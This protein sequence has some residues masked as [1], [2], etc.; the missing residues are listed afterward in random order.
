[1][2]ER[3]PW[4]DD[5][6]A[7]AFAARADD[8]AA[9]TPADLATTTIQLIRDTAASSRGWHQGT[10]PIVAL[11][12]VAVVVAVVAAVTL[13]PRLSADRGAAT[14]PPATLPASTV[15][16]DGSA[17]PVASASRER[18]GLVGVRPPDHLGA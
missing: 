15:P 10:R 18:G 6:L 1:M 7:A 11:L 2:S 3:E 4:D 12:G 5:R 14:A 9:A 17:S 8:P 16:I 13:G